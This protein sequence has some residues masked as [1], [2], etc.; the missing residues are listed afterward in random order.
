MFSFIKERMK[1]LKVSHP[2]KHISQ[3][4]SKRLHAALSFSTFSTK[5]FP[6]RATL[7]SIPYLNLNTKFSFIIPLSSAVSLLVLCLCGLAVRE[8]SLALRAAGPKISCYKCTVVFV[9]FCTSAGRPRITLVLSP[10][11]GKV[12]LTRLRS[13]NL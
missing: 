4:F 11:N 9:F 12:T 1:I 2:W 3:D 13:G 7:Q 8:F 10:S 5:Q 6:C